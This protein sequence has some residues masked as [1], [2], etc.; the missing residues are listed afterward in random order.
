MLFSPAAPVATAL[1]ISLT[2]FIDF[3]ISSGAKRITKVRELMNRGAYGP[4]KDFYR[5]LREGL[6]D[7]H[8]AGGTLAELRALA[9]HPNPDKAQIYAAMVQGYAKFIGR[10]NCVWLPAPRAQ[11]QHRELTVRLNPE[12]YALLDD[13]PTLAK[14]YLRKG[15]RPTRDKTCAVV[16]LLEEELHAQVEPNTKFGVLDVQRG[17]FLSRDSRH[18]D[19]RALLRAEAET[20]IS[21][22]HDLATKS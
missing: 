20:F 21:L 13:Q 9:Q 12:F 11:W 17:T 15:E 18:H 10:R 4:E 2:D 6:A 1:T 8:R 22:W 5:H 14:L 16:N 3:A 7:W 19:L